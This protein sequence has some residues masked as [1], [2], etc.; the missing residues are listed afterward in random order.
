MKAMNGAAMNPMDLVMFRPTPRYRWVTCEDPDLI[1]ESG[2]PFRA[3]ILVSLTGDQII[4][5]GK[6]VMPWREAAE[7]MAPMVRAWN[8]ETP[9]PAEAGPEALLAIDISLLEWVWLQI[10]IAR[11]GGPERKNSPTPATP[12]DAKQAEDEDE[13]VIVVA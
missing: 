4:E 3:E 11:F 8:F 12:L 2:T 13:G 5:V 10:R 9:P 1:D 6:P 7:L